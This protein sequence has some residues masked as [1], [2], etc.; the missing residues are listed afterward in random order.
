MECFIADFL[1][2]CDENVKIW[3]L[4]VQLGTGHEIQVFQGFS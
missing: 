3:L 4:G 1:R 2:V